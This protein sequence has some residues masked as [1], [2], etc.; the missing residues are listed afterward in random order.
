MF[1]ASTGRL[2]GPL[3]WCSKRNIAGQVFL[4]I[5]VPEAEVICAVA[6]Q[7]TG[8]GSEE[9]V[10]EYFLEYS[11]DGFNWQVVQED[12]KLKVLFD[13]KVRTIFLCNKLTSVSYAPVF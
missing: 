6:T 4:Q 5:H 7:G 2:N 13:F 10:K 1:E 9:H 3:S 12:G 11:K 8:L